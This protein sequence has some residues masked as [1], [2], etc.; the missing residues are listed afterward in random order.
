MA[1][2]ADGSVLA[3]RLAALSAG[4]QDVFQGLFAIDYVLAKP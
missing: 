2:A 1:G 3:G 4:W